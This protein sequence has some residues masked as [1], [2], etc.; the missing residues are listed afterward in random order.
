MKNVQIQ[1]A[2]WSGQSVL[3]ESS[4]AFWDEIPTQGLGQHL[5]GFYFG[6]LGAV[7]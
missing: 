4:D 1:E 2:S 3:G 5:E 6:L 7:P